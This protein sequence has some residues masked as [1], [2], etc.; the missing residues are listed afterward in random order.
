MAKRWLLLALF[1]VLIIYSTSNYLLG[2]EWQWTTEI[3]G[4]ISPETNA[5]PR[6]FL[7]IPPTCS[8]VHAVIIGQH[9]MEEEP[10][11]ED[12]SFRQTLAKLDIAA[13][14]ITPA[15]DNGAHL[16][17]GAGDKLLS[18]LTELGQRS[19]Y[20]EL[21]DAPII[22]I[23]HSAMAS[24]PWEFAAWKPS[25]TL[26]A[27]S[28]SGQWPYTPAVREQFPAN[29][30]LDGVPGLVTLG[31]Y[32]WAEDRAKEGLAQLAQHPHLPLTMLAEPGS[33]HFAPTPAKIAL[34]GLYLSK[35][36]AARL[37]TQPPTSGPIPLIPIDATKTGW[38]YDRWHKN[39]EA[40]SPAGSVTGPLS[41]TG[42]RRQAFWCFDGELA[43][44][45]H[46][47]GNRYRGRA[48]QLLGYVQNG[49]VL[50]QNKETHQQVTLDWLPEAD[51]ISFKV[52]GCFLDTVP[53]GRP[54]KWV[55]KPAGSLIDHAA[56]ADP[57]I[58]ER[59]CGPVRCTGP[60]TFCI[61]FTRQGTDNPRRSNEIWLVA[62]HP[63]DA[64]FKPA[65]QQAV[66]HFPLRNTT[67]SEQHLNF[68]AI[69]D[70]I[71]GT[72]NPILLSA[73]ASSGLPVG[74]YVLAGPA[75]VEGNLLRFTTLPPRASLPITVT[76][77]AWQWGRS[78]SPEVKTADPVV[79]SFLIQR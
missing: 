56:S 49:K 43:S 3:T 11:L 79:R 41:Y 32:E 52:S 47:F 68:P 6:A 21:A 36:M 30:H 69:P 34:L 64:R 18:L 65:E 72:T 58:I 17:D 63:G 7:W 73:T 23:G 77:V 15:L 75:E 33:G 51:G 19:G 76:I 62:R 31:E 40:K 8:K 48:G 74:Y 16:A 12:A 66:L 9:N 13:I 10:I 20:V 5:Q 35:A 55:G 24:F 29:W 1:G 59:I 44:A 54:E 42:D 14:W 28:I 61:A 57:I 37:P 26:A 4:A 78:I 22:P 45:I 60:N 53:A 38:L 50:N 67:G 2:A 70:Q 46:D 25:R 39:Q 71:A 27:I